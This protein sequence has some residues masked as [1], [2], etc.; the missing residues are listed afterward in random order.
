MANSTAASAT[1]PE[2]VPGPP[3]PESVPAAAAA[4][5]WRNRTLMSLLAGQ[6]LSVLGDGLYNV[7]LLW[8]VYQETSSS[9]ITSTVLLAGHLP[10]IVLGPFAGVLV[11]R[12]DRRRIM[13]VTDIVRGLAVTALAAA[14]GAGAMRIWHVLLVQVVLSFGWA[15]FGPAYMA[16]VPNIVPPPQLSRANTLSQMAMMLGF[17]VGPAIGGVALGWFGV[18][19]S[20]WADAV[21]FAISAAALASVSF[22]SPRSTGDRPAV[23]GEMAEGFRIFVGQR[24]LFSM[25]LLVIG[26]NM[27]AGG[28]VALMPAIAAGLGAGPRGYGLMEAAIP[29]GYVISGG[30]LATRGELRRQ[31]VVFHAGVAGA[32]LL[33]AVF[34]LSRSYPLSLGLLLGI[35]SLVAAIDTVFVTVIQR[36]IPDAARGRAFALAMTLAQGLRPVGM[37][38]SGALADRFSAFTVV[39]IAGVAIA[40]GGLYGLSVPGLRRIEAEAPDADAP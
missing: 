24:A 20:L 16:S 28:V 17:F 8:W 14:S 37:A 35:G 30:V 13:L 9:L 34:G 38:A 10:R 40:L 1:A 21:S 19:G 12:F 5:I 2:P 22:P 31:G 36:A 29:L 6:A 32:G 18:A 11:D 33:L 39:A 23:M 15:F 7:A 25:V 4:P 26:V 27:F 3:A